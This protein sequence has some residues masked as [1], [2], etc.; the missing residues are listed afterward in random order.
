LVHAAKIKGTSWVVL[1]GGFC[2]VEVTSVDDLLQRVGEAVSPCVLQ[3]FDADRVAG[4]EHLR[5]AAVNAVKAFEA[6]ASFSKSLAV[7]VLLYASCQDQISRAFDILGISTATRRVALLVM[8]QDPDE[9][10]RALGRASRILGTVDDS[11]FSVNDK[12]FELLRQTYSVS[13]AELKALGGRREEAL[14]RLIVERGA[15]LAVHR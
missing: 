14:T 7:E 3:V 9:A 12:K 1:V 5:F 15:L 13:D 10:A 2:G 6:G 11:V 8:G 4:W